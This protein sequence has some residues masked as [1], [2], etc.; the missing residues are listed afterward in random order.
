MN[1]YFNY[2]VKLSKAKEGGYIV[3]FPDLPEAL[4]QGESIEHALQ[5]ASDCLEEAI[6]NRM[7]MKLPIPA[8]SMPKKNQHTVLLHATLA[9]KVALYIAVQEAK[10]NNIKL[11]KKLQ[12]DEKEVRRMLDP[13]HIS[14]L[15]RI[16]SALEKLGRRL[17]IGIVSTASTS[18]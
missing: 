18:L 5:E 14:K 6:A 16:E 11:A 7:T 17:S 12:C 2:P 13:H 10:L 4:T 8:A 1:Q 15:T 3:K 9:T